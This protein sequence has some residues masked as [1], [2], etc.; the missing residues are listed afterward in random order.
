MIVFNFVLT[1][2][3]YGQI[4]ECSHKLSIN[5]LGLLSECRTGRLEEQ[6]PVNRVLTRYRTES[7]KIRKERYR[8]AM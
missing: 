4:D 3:G 5:L 2:D 6:N 8:I 7:Q 1:G